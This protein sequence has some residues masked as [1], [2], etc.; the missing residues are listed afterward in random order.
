MN[1]N[2]KI[3]TVLYNKKAWDSQVRRGNRWTV[4]VSPEEVKAARSGPLSLLLTP[5]KF[6]PQ[7][8]YPELKGC[9]VLALASGGGQQGPL[10]AARGADVTILDNSPLQ[11]ERDREVAAREGLILKTEEGDMGDLSR[12]A[13]G[14]FD[15]IFHPCSNVFVEDVNRTWREAFRVLRKGGTMI[16]GFCNPVIFTLDLDLEKSGVAQMRYAIPY[17]DLILNEDEREKYFGPD[18]PLNFGHT[19]DDQIGGQLAA[20]FMLTGFYEDGWDAEVSP[21]HRYLKCFIATRAWKPA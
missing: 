8:W 4:P 13:D 17:S 16:S 14:S 3:D 5:Q 12:F 2:S 11:L 7:D 6:V 20:G 18:E 10:L 21:I 15:F 1:Q 9:K 19:L